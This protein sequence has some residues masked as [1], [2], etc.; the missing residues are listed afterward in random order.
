HREFEWGQEADADLVVDRIGTSSLVIL[1]S[2]AER[3]AALARARAA[4]PP[5]RFRLPYVCH[6]WRATRV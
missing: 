1:M 3:A 6:A 2:G 4:V 5:G